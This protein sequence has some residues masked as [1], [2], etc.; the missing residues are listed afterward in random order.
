MIEQYRTYHYN[1]GF[2]FRLEGIVNV[3]ENRTGALISLTS[4]ENVVVIPGW[5]AVSSKVYIPP[6]VPVIEPNEFDDIPF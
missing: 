3:Q 2:N 6:A 4:G 5:I 1:N